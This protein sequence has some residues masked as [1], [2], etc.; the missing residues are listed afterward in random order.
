MW[1]SAC[2]LGTGVGWRGEAAYRC[3]QPACR[4][5]A[6]VAE[7]GESVCKKHRGRERIRRVGY[8]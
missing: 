3:Y 8:R 2:G 1:P 7:G 5:L 4:L 6:E